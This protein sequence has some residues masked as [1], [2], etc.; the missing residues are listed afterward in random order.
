MD[1]F[2]YYVCEEAY[3]N[4]VYRYTY[5]VKSYNYYLNELDFQTVCLNKCITIL[6]GCSCLGFNVH[7]QSKLLYHTHV[8]G[9]HSSLSG[10]KVSS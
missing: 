10:Q 9:T 1:E 2:A 5:K 4:N 3:Y 6:P 7:I 8:M